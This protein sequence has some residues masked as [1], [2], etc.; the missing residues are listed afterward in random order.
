MRKVYLGLLLMGVFLL[1]G[2]GK[3]GGCGNVGLDKENCN[4]QIDDDQDG[5]VDCDDDDCEDDILCAVTAESNC[6]DG[7]DNNND[8]D[9]DCADSTCNTDS[10][11]VG[12]SCEGAQTLN[13]GTTFSTNISTLDLIRSNCEEVGTA[14]KVDFVHS[15]TPLA[16]G[17]L[18]IDLVEA[19]GANEDFGLEVVSDCLDLETEIACSDSVGVSLPESVTVPVTGGVP[20]FI[21]VNSFNSFK[22]YNITLT[23]Q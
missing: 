15:F 3:G 2:G 19:T 8:G 16:N 17:N 4:N 11:C 7:V 20:I 21:I 12:Q 6:T 1:T 23:Q 18:T 5:Q 10:E 22:A 13:L 9:I 14:P